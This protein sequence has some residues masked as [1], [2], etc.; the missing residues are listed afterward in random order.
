MAPLF[1][2]FLLVALALSDA[3]D[4]EPGPTKPLNTNFI[5]ADQKQGGA[6]A[7]AIK[8]EKDEQDAQDAI[9]ASAAE[10]AWREVQMCPATDGSG[11]GDVRH[12][13]FSALCQLCLTPLLS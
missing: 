8:A 5:T 6:F 10:E 12:A 1:Y 3:Y 4:P 9:A 13:S 11:S 2:G 7:A